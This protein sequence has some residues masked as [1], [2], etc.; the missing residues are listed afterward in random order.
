MVDRKKSQIG[1]LENWQ[2]SWQWDSDDAKIM[3]IIHYF[4]VDTQNNNDS[5]SIYADFIHFLF[6]MQTSLDEPF[7]TFSRNVLFGWKN[8]LHRD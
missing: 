4:A 5:L 8:T 1:I 3:C 7:W 6:V 2:P